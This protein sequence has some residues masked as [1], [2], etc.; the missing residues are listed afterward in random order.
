[1]KE[2]EKDRERMLQA[3][4]CSLLCKLIDFDLHALFACLKCFPL[5][6]FAP[7]G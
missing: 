1:M 7:G 6:L 5:R 2:I 4:T 3:V